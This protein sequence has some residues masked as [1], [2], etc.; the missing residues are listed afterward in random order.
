MTSPPSRP[1]GRQERRRRQ[2]KQGQV[3]PWD[4]S[5]LP[6]PRLWEEG[7]LHD[8][9]PG[10]LIPRL[11]RCR[12]VTPSWRWVGDGGRRWVPRK[13]PCRRCFAPG[14]LTSPASAGASEMLSL[15]RKDRFGREP[16]CPSEVFPPHRGGAGLRGC[17]RALCWPNS[18]LLGQAP[19]PAASQEPCQEPVAEPPW[20][21]PAA[22]LSAWARTGSFGFS[23]DLPVA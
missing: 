21:L 12:R 8:S 20:E 1:C 19:W 23:A 5:P 17:S 22:T 11:C 3:V 13:H 16:Q 15:G 2:L 4:P 9:H 10:M 14:A 7:H 18:W 6:T